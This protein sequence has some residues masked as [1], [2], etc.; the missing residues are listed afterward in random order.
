VRLA[1]K[2]PN[3][4]F[5]GEGLLRSDSTSPLQRLLCAVKHEVSSYK[6]M[7]KPVRGLIPLIET[8]PA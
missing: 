7:R 6:L 8:N 3:P 1:Y 5:S 2:V 4:K